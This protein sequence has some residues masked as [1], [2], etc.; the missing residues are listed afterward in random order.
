MPGDTELAAPA[1]GGVPSG[2]AYTVIGRPRRV[3]APMSHLLAALSARRRELLVLFSAAAMVL[4]GLGGLAWLFGVDSGPAGI[5]A[6][7]AFLWSFSTMT[8]SGVFSLAP[9]SWVGRLIQLSLVVLGIALI[10][11]LT[12]VLS[13]GFSASVEEEGRKRTARERRDLLIEAFSIQPTIPDRKLVARLGMT[14]ARRRFLSFETIAAEL[15]FPSDAVLEVMKHHPEFRLR[16]VATKAGSFDTRLVVEHFLANRPYGGHRRLAG[17]RVHV[18]STQSNADAFVGHFA[19]CLAERM[20]ASYY[21][22]EYFSSGSLL[23]RERVNFASNEGYFLP[24]LLI[25]SPALAAFRADVVNNIQVGDL[26]IYVG[27]SS[28]KADSL[29]LSLTLPALLADAGR[30]CTIDGDAD[31]LSAELESRMGGITLDGD[32]PLTLGREGPYSLGPRPHLSRFL[33]DVMR[34]Q[35]I[36]VYA[37]TTLLRHSSNAAYYGAIAALAGAAEAVCAGPLSGPREGAE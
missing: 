25:D 34:A 30:R 31:R 36:T 32:A 20:A 1:P 24:A 29:H 10:S 12:G 37:N 11:L 19:G 7:S 6:E 18:I 5:E 28:A 2:G 13:S 8:N 4:F 3:P 15:R 16:E 22:N 27:T 26:V 21:S 33:R 9:G 35:V 23:A 14:A 17:A